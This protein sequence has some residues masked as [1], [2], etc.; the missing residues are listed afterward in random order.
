MKSRIL[1]WNCQGAGH[2]KFHRFLKEYLR[3]FDPD[4]V[5]LVETRVSGRKADCVVGKIGL[6][7]SY[8]IEARGFAGGIWV[9]W[10]DSIY[11]SPQRMKRKELWNGI[12]YLA[13]GVQSPWLIAG[14]FNAMLNNDEKKGG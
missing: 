8:R 4:I 5:I 6:P 7:Y 2:P 10:Q 14:D 3:D 1:V 12:G 11:G 13:Q 9:M